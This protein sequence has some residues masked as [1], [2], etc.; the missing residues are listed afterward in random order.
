VCIAAW[1]SPAPASSHPNPLPPVLP[2]LLLTKLCRQASGRVATLDGGGRHPNRAP[3][4]ARGKGVLAGT[5][6]PGRGMAAR[7]HRRASPPL[8]SLPLGDVGVMNCSPAPPSASSS[9]TA[10]STYIPN[11]TLRHV[12]TV[13][14]AAIGLRRRV[15][16]PEEL[17]LAGCRHPRPPSRRRPQ[18]PPRR[19][20]LPSS[21]TAPTPTPCRCRPCPGPRTRTKEPIARLL[22]DAYAGRFHGHAR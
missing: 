6:F 13:L 20:P 12:P 7:R 10:S 8:P 9:V 14:V 4:A 17:G 11:A 5:A 19:A 1:A 21:H 22:D 15:G 3:G 18:A 16:Q 2:W